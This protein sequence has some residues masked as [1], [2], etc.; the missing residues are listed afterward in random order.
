VVCDVDPSPV[1]LCEDDE[2]LQTG[3]AVLQE[4]GVGCLP[5]VICWIFHIF[6]FLQFVVLFS[7]I[8]RCYFLL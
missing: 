3:G 1:A 4:V 6:I 7:R 8:F 5:P 2:L